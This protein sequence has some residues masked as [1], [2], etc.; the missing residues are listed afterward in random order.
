MWP[1]TEP[2]QMYGI[3]ML[4]NAS[5]LSSAM[6]VE[7]KNFECKL[8]HTHHFCKIIETNFEQIKCM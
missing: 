7:T 6:N 3:F 5:L 1:K 2:L 8:T 4:G